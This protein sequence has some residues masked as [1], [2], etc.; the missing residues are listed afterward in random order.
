[1]IIKKEV[2]YALK[3]IYRKRQSILRMSISYLKNL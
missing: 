3:I 2:K 1:M